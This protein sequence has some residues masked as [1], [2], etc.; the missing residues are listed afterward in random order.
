[1]STRRTRPAGVSLLTVAQAARPAERHPRTVR[2]M[3]ARGQLTWLPPRQPNDP[4]RPSR[5][6]PLPGRDPERPFAVGA[7]MKATGGCNP[8]VIFAIREARGLNVYEKVLLFIIESRGVLYTSARRTAQDMGVA[9]STYY[10]TV[11]SLQAKGLISSERAWGNDG[12]PM[13]TRYRVNGEA[14][15]R[16]AD[17]PPHNAERHGSS[18]GGGEDSIRGPGA[19]GG[20]PGEVANRT[21]PLHDVVPEE[22]QE[23]NQKEDQEE[24]QEENQKRNL[25]RAWRKTATPARP[26][27]WRETRLS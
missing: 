10:K 7:V 14:V 1:M 5:D 27:S 11:R 4:R 24:N 22:N 13:P 19:P 20:A 18:S 16:L 17:H 2:R 23:E 6:R 3:I 25:R 21:A 8:T 15:M 9:E 12:G 26:I